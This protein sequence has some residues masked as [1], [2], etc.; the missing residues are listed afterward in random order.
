[1]AGLKYSEILGR[2]IRKDDWNELSVSTW[3]KIKGA[4]KGNRLKEAEELI[5]YL[6][7]EGKRAHDVFVDWVYGLLNYISD[8]LGEEEIYNALWYTGEL[9]WKPLITIASKV[10]VEELVQINA[11]NQRAH[12]SEIKIVGE[13]DKYIISLDP[14]GTGGRMRRGGEVDGTPPRTGPPYNF[15]KTRKPYFWSWSKV[16]VPYHCTHCCVWSEIMPIEMIGYP[17]RINEY[18]DDPN[19]PCKWLFYKKPELIPDRYFERI[20]KKKKIQNKKAN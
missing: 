18:S 12:R 2:N 14:C 16:G 5:D 4:I 8:K 20:G 11:E 1:M 6:D 7:P 13:I 19:E 17:L 9:I 15:G 3:T 10:S